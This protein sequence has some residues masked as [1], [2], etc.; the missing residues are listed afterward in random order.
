MMDTC[1][2]PALPSGL[3]FVRPAACCA[4]CHLFWP[5]WHLKF[6]RIVQSCFCDTSV[7]HSCVVPNAVMITI[8]HST[9]LFLFVYLTRASTGKNEIQRSG[10]FWVLKCGV[11]DRFLH[12]AVVK[13]WAAAL[14][15]SRM[16]LASKIK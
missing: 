11:L 9:V 6:T 10:I 7:F 8:V 2:S 15:T 3:Q 4:T 13:R 1:L 12:L 5:D 16:W 14:P